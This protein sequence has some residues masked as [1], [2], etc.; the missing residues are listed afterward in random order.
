MNSTLALLL[1]SAGVAGL[2]YLDRDK[3]VRMSKAF[4]LPVFW[5]LIAGSRPVSSWFGIGSD[6]EG[7]IAAT[8][9]GSPMD[10]FVFE[11]L[12]VA[13]IIALFQRRSR[14]QSRSS[15]RALPY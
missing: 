10:A 6:T 7:S 12:I 15:K 11:V 14:D 3:T 9:D 5:L 1:F 8:L 4:W 13:G 2:F